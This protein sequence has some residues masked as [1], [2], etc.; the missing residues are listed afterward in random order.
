MIG[1]GKPTPTPN[2]LEEYIDLLLERAL[3][4]GITELNFWDMTPGEVIRAIESNNRI[5]K[6]QA[7]E[8]A[9]YDYIQASLIIKGISICLGDKS[10]YPTLQEA[11]PGLFEE[12]A[13]EQEEKIQ[14]QKMEVSALRFKQF[15][16]TYNKK[17]NKEVPK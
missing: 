4:S 11:Y 8:K 16:Q 15:A 1:E 7:Q 3:D 12:I 5:V 13:Q 6:L 17:F 2:T 14:Q 9:S 10:N